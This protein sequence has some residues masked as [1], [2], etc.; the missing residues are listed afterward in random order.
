MSQNTGWFRFYDRMIDSPQVL[1]LNDTEFR[2][3]VSAWCLASAAETRGTLPFSARAIQRRVLPDHSVD[4]VQQ[5]LTHLT[6][7]H[8]ITSLSDGCGYVIE[9]WDKHQYKYPSLTPDARR[10]QKRKERQA[11]DNTADD[12]SQECRNDVA[13]CRNVDTDIELDLDTEE[14]SSYPKVSSSSDTNTPSQAMDTIVPSKAR[15]SK[16]TASKPENVTQLPTGQARNPI[17]DALVE[18]FGDAQKT[19]PER[20]NWG[21]CVK[22]LKAVD[23]TPEEMRVRA[24][25]YSAKYGRDRLTPN[26]LVSHWSEFASDPPRGTA[27]PPSQPRA[28]AANGGSYYRTRAPEP[29]P[30]YEPYDPVKHSPWNSTPSEPSPLL[31]RMR[32]VAPITAESE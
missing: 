24:A 16:K 8:L 28:M 29:E 22:N 2:L 21:K 32:K 25:R 19:A 4:E 3:L 30:Y 26:A 15:T 7:L 27:S 6:E 14:D 9:N 13:T 1:E 11:S 5:M 10:E 17:W 23:A 12:M 31:A 20:S 18:I